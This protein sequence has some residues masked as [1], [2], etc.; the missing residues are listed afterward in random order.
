MTVTQARTHAATPPDE[1][2]E[3]FIGRCKHKPVTFGS[4][5]AATD[6]LFDLLV[7]MKEN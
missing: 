3:E 4:L 2:W 6:T 7:R 5:G 1:E